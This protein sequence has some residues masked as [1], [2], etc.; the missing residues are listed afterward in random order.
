MKDQMTSR[1]FHVISHLERVRNH[2]SFEVE[3]EEL[4]AVT[5]SGAPDG[6]VGPGGLLG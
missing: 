6:R 2:V 4:D 3:Q 1:L 5:R